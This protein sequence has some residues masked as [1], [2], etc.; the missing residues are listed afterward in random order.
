MFD[1][2]GVCFWGVLGLML[3]LCLCFVGCCGFVG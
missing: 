3:L 2:V 1:Y